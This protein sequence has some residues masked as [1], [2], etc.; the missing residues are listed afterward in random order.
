MSWA[1]RAYRRVARAFP[2]EFTMVYGAD[3]AQLGD[4]VID[5]IAK[6]EGLA[7]LLRM[8]ADVVL[9]LAIE[10]LVELRG[11]VRYALRALRQS[12]GFALVGILSTGIGMG[13]TT[14]VYASKWQIISRQLP[15]AHP[16]RLVMPDKPVSY[17]HV[18]AYRQENRIFAGVAAFE[19]GVAFS[20]RFTE[21]ES[22]KPQRIFGQLVSPD[23]FS[24]LG[25]RAQAGRV[26]SASE[27]HPGDAP[28]IVVSDRF[29]RARLGAASDVVGRALRIN[30]QLVTIVGVA[31]RDFDGVLPINPSELFVPITVRRAVAP[32]LADD[33]LHRS[34]ARQFLA[35]A[36]L[37][38][39][40]AVDVAEGVLATVNRRLAAEDTSLRVR[41]DTVRRVPLVA[42]GGM[43]PLPRDVK[44]LISAFFAALMGLIMTIACMNL[45]SMLVARGANRRRE[46]AIRLAVGASRFRLVRQLMAEGVVLS[47]LGGVLG[48]AL[49][50][51]LIALKMKYAA[52]SA[53]PI[54]SAIKPG[55]S[56]A[57]FAF[58]LA[59]VCGCGFSLA[60]ALRATRADVTP[61][62]KD[63][64]GLQLPGHRRLG[65]RNL[66]MV[67]QLTGSLALLMITGFLVLGLSQSG[68]VE[69]R[70]DPRDAQLLA[71]D[72]A[73][74]GYAPHR[75]VAFFERL[76]DRLRGIAGVRF[77][78]L[79]AQPPFAVED[80]DATVPVNS[81]GGAGGARIQA[82]V[83][84]DVVGSGFFAALEEPM[85]A[86]REFT[87]EDERLPDS[88]RVLPVI[89][90]GSAAAALFTS[91]NAV[92][93]R[94]RD[95]ARTYEVVG[96]VRDL[97][98][99]L[100]VIP[101]L[102]YLP[103]RQVAFT[104]PPAGGIT[105]IV[106]GD[107]SVIRA[108][109]REIE[110]QDPSLTVFDV[111]SL[112]EYL[113]RS[114]A[115]ERYALDTYAAI[116]VFS[117]VLAAIGLAGVTAYAAA[118]RRKEIGIRV[119]LGA[120]TE[121][122]L[123]L[124]LREG[125]A[126]VSVGTVLGLLGAVGM[127]RVMAALT[128][129]FARALRVGTGDPRLV[130][131]APLL[132]A[133]LALLASYVPARRATRIAPLSALRSQ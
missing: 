44:P 58:G 27:D 17:H 104:T 78:A 68:Q 74:D 76:P 43:V 102:M 29:W 131:G 39:G 38:P 57:W 122:V 69:T 7:G 41:G 63:G 33:V 85:L 109:Q 120:R 54:V 97:K 56:A 20:V 96:V 83:K 86:G 35:L 72:P 10:Y 98:N 52:P 123:F 129:T 77:V 13:L 66:L 114:R 46:F 2:H 22:G 42:A 87:A 8:L 53:Q 121:Q 81:D 108:V 25:V 51:L 116:G 18:E 125:L 126:L 61:A 55:W 6:R 62:L 106:R 124:V 31:P 14:T 93:G 100:Q 118:Q 19:P 94:L 12:P 65:L 32:E 90:N 110:S 127:A 119:A 11:D 26:F 128:D 28:A 95:G 23:Y 30:E 79:A 47:L 75:S 117:L 37:A 99:G 130:F 60:P 84:K 70:F 59:L 88:T 115:A 112:A 80:E 21:D 92:G 34:D 1:S 101:S 15:V 40:V 4:D 73:R 3:M 16:D 50:Y 133:G 49:A 89:L 24:V 111:R 113:E 82:S 132:L 48:F 36:R 107:P 45:G 91:G 67:A 9:R 5:D 71:L 105:V 64:S 103:L